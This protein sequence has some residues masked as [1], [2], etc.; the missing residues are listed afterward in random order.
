M[1]GSFITVLCEECGMVYND[2]F[3]L[4]TKCPECKHIEFIGTTTPEL[5]RG[6][7]TKC[8]TCP[9]SL[10]VCQEC[11]YAVPWDTV[12]E[13]VVRDERQLVQEEVYEKVVFESIESTPKVQV[14]VA[15]GELRVFIRHIGF[16][17]NARRFFRHHYIGKCGY[18]VRYFHDGELHKNGW[19]NLPEDQWGTDTE[20]FEVECDAC[21]TDYDAMGRTGTVLECPMCGESDVLE[22]VE[23]EAQ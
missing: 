3:E 8:T 11:E 19:Y 12:L 23:E 4:E 18:M 16:Q 2:K 6:N 20:H 13:P 9:F 14:K 15:E 5:K 7:S 10:D 22:L 17:P 1:R 21:G